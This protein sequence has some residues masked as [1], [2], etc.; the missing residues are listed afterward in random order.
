MLCKKNLELYMKNQNIIKENAKLREKA[1][2]LNEENKVLLALLRTSSSSLQEKETT[3]TAT[4]TTHY[5][6]C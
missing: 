2:Y 3:T 1:T 5:E 4:T 6:S